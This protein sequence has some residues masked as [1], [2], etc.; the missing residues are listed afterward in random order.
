MYL[1]LRVLTTMDELQLELE[2][3]LL[4]ALGLLIELA[5]TWLFMNRPEGGGLVK[6]ECT[7]ILELEL[8]L[9]L[10]VEVWGGVGMGV[11][12][13]GGP[14]PGNAVILKSHPTHRK[15]G[16]WGQVKRSSSDYVEV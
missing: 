11:W 12:A 7:I 6:F 4:L 1:E 9:E 8:E 5:E 14:V 16:G 15:W 10:V 13:L 2:L 3:G